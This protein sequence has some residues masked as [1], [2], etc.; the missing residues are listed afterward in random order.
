VNKVR[1]E[2][3]DNPENPKKS[4]DLEMD[5]IT[6]IKG[7]LSEMHS[8][9]KKVMEYSNRLHFETALESSRQEYSHAL[10]NYLFEDIGTGL[11]RNMVKKCPEKG[12]CTSAFT[13]ILQHNEGLI[14]YNKVDEALIS[15]NRK[16][17]DELKCGAPYK[18]CERCFSEVSSLFLKQINLMRSMNIYE[19]NQ[20]QKPDISALKT[21][22]F[23]SEILEP[24]SNKQ[25]L[26]ILKA[27]AFE[28]KSFSAFSKLT[29]LIAGNL[30]FH[31]QKLMDCEL[32]MQQH[33]RGD[34]IITEKGFKILQ[35]LNEI[36]LSCQYFPQQIY[37]SNLLEK[38]K[39]EKLIDE[40]TM[41]ELTKTLKEMAL[42]LGAFKVGIA[43]TKTLLGGPPSADLTYVLPEAKS[44]VCIALAFDQSL[45]DP[46][47]RKVDH[48][49]LETNKVQITTLATGIVL[50]MA[51]FLQH[52]GYKA[53]PQA[54]NFAY[55]RDTENL[56]LD[57]HPPISHRYLAVRSGIGHFGYSGN[58]ITKEYGSAIV[59]VSVVTNA[60]LIPTDS[61]PE[62][63][64]Y[65]D[66]CKLCLS[67]CS[68]GYV[69]PVEK[70][71]VTLGGKE[72]SYGKRRSNCRC[73]FVCGGLTGLNATGKWST[74][75]PGR[76][77]IPEKDEDFISAISAAT[78]AYL[79]R[80]KFKGGFFVPII[81]DPRW[82]I[83]VL[84]AN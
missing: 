70:V 80:P 54:A 39:K 40:S 34:Y 79:E 7:K 67:V 22:I 29:G 38:S 69:D 33:E 31:L 50:E 18:K 35:G 42:T 60:E 4:E 66:E 46:F 27:V 49:S 26:E 55:R 8:D 47:F 20:G 41:V 61:L 16:K 1:N 52:S 63:E 53:V 17:L 14:K 78:Q 12:N 24:V 2:K 9:I 65:C 72:F 11:E 76:F 44:A 25:R 3:E 68:S 62:E 57:L 21:S 81:P 51:N 84:T 10:Q 30:F 28:P 71:T 77:K 58:I 45:I 48:E 32:I 15:D 73:L 23:M 6:A 75:S 37:H 74:W 19:N 83:P 5:E 56:L 43:T 64:N 13:T 59:L 82:N 36:Y